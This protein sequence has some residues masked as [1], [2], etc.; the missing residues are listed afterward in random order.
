M[1]K[2]VELTEEEIEERKRR[3]KTASPELVAQYKPLFGN[4]KKGKKYKVVLDPGEDR[5]KVKR[6][7]KLV[8][9]ALN[10]PI[11]FLQTRGAV[12]FDVRE[13]TEEEKAAIQKRVEGRRAK[14]E[15]AQS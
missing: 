14:K 15:A 7:V 6:E 9:T 13:Q 8:A 5:E 4:V 11:V 10:I 12:E 1:P 3:G 2:I